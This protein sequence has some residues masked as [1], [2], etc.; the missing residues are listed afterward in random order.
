MGPWLLPIEVYHLCIF[1]DFYHLYII[2]FFTISTCSLCNF[3]KCW[4]FSRFCPRSSLPNSYSGW[5][6]LHISG[7]NDHLCADDS[8][9]YNCHCR[10]SSELQTL[11]SRLSPSQLHLAAQTPHS[12]RIKVAGSLPAETCPPPQWA[13]PPGNQAQTPPSPFS[14]MHLVPEPCWFPPLL[15]PLSPPYLKSLPCPGGPAAPSWALC[16]PL[17]PSTSQ[18][19]GSS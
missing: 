4:L 9:I 18:L 1:S 17:A 7:F 11:K 10:F 14:L 13:S 19:K 15:S 16:S 6:R 5:D 2:Y 3:L 8:Q 12:A